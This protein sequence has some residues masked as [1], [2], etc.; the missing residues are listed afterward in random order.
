MTVLRSQGCLM[1][2]VLLTTSCGAPKPP[3]VPP[4]PPASNHA[5]SVAQ[6]G[7][8]QVEAAAPKATDLGALAANFLTAFRDGEPTALSPLACRTFQFR[9]TARVDE[10]GGTAN[11]PEE[12][13]RLVRCVRADATLQRVLQYASGLP[14]SVAAIPALPGWAVPLVSASARAQP[15]A[16]AYINGDGVTFRFVLISSGECVEWLLLTAEFEAG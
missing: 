5:R 6:S 4:S 11:T 9:S 2:S 16:D 15:A 12:L 3:P 14:A 1:F 10:C 8:E 13:D 7:G